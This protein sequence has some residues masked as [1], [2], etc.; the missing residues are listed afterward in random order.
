MQRL[1]QIED[2]HK[3]NRAH[4]DKRHITSHRQNTQ[5]KS[6]QC[7]DLCRHAFIRK[8]PRYRTHLHQISCNDKG[9]K[10]KTESKR[11][12]ITRNGTQQARQSAQKSHKSKSAYTR[13]TRPR[14]MLPVAPAAFEPDNQPDPERQRQSLIDLVNRGK[15]KNTVQTTLLIQRT[16]RGTMIA[17]RPARDDED[18]R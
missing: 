17:G 15:G 10:T 18:G 4:R 3:H 11:Q 1:F 8:A 12:P 5:H 13:S 9:K 16:T 2:S 14:G 7:G 6:N